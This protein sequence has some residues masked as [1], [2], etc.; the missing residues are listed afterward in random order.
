MHV[1]YFHIAST[2]HS[3]EIKIKPSFYALEY[4]HK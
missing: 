3:V 2:V 1:Y 4:V